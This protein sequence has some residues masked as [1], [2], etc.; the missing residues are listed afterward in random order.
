MFAVTSERRNVPGFRIRVEPGLAHLL[1]AKACCGYCGKV[2]VVR[3]SLS[4][5]DEIVGLNRVQRVLNVSALVV[6]AELT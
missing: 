1:A 6:P 4:S 5:G 3:A 2:R